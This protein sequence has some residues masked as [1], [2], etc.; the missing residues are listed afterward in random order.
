MLTGASK[1]AT[2]ERVPCIRYPVR[3][4]K[5]IVAIAFDCFPASCSLYSAEAEDTSNDSE[6]FRYTIKN[7]GFW[8][9]AYIQRESPTWA[10]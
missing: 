7:P 4:R 3:F 5:D 10:E 8:K 9:E 2:L 1:K 6:D